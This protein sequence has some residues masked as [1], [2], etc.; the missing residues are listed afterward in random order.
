M[1]DAEGHE[2]DFDGNAYH[3]EKSR[4]SFPMAV[5]WPVDNSSINKT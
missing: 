5:M 2:T 1:L 3:F 4:R